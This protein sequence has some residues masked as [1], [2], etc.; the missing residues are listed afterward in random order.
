MSWQISYLKPIKLIG[1]K[2]PFLKAAFFDL[3]FTYFFTDAGVLAG[4]TAIVLAV[5]STAFRTGSTVVHFTIAAWSVG[6][7]D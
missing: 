3:Q 2:P 1:K 6:K 4:L 5:W 7:S